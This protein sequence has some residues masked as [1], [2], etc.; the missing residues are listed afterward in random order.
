MKTILSLVL[1]LCLSA[2]LLSGTSKTNQ[3]KNDAIGLAEEI[4]TGS[5]TLIIFSS[6]DCDVLKEASELKRTKEFELKGIRIK[7]IS[8]FQNRFSALD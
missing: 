7:P 2:I 3:K 5:K 6:T 8:H 4:R 1:I